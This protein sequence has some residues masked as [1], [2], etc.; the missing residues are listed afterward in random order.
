MAESKNNII[1]R[2]MSGSIGKQLVFK[3]YGDRTIV[4]AMPDM[5]RVVKSKKQKAENNKF[6][7]AIAYARSQMV[8]P[9]SKVE[10]KA[11]A[12]GLQKPHNVAIADFYNPPEIRKVDTTNIRE[13][14][15]VTV[16]AIDDFK[17]TDVTVEVYDMDGVLLEQGHA[18][19]ISQ[20]FWTY[21]IMGDISTFK[22]IRLLV[23]AFDKPGNK[24][25]QE[26]EV[27]L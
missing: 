14:K 13:T 22:G 23:A 4:S 7:E 20:W 5:S 10:Y 25:T 16:H 2:G 19:E 11:K 17:V 12:K 8:D 6:R 21:R 9:V 15:T 18:V 27:S 1:V 3:Q 26:I 24:T